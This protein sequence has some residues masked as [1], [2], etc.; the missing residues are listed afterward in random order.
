MVIGDDRRAGAVESFLHG[1][2]DL[3]AARRGLDGLASG[4]RTVEPKTRLRLGL[5]QR[6]NR[7]DRH[8]SAH[9]IG[10]GNALESY[11]EDG[12][13]GGARRPAPVQLGRD[14][15]RALARLALVDQACRRGDLEVYAMI[16]GALA[17]DV[18]ILFETGSADQPR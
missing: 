4:H 3:A 1:G 14:E 18:R 17:E 5:E 12:D 9:V 15:V 2:A 7:S 16:A 13:C 11:S 8:G 10:L 6:I